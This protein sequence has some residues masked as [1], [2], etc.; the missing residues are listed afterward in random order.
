MGRRIIS[1]EI[2]RTIQV[3]ELERQ[4]K[5]GPKIHNAFSFPTPVRMEE[6]GYIHDPET[7]GEA[8]K[9]KLL[10]EGMHGK[11]LI[12]VLSSSKIAN[13]EVTIPLVKK[14]KIRSVIQYNASEYFPV[15]LAN[16]HVTYK[17][18]EQV[19]TEEGKGLRMLVLAVPMDL[20]RS[21]ADLGR[22]MGMHVLELDYAGNACFQVLKLAAPTGVAVNVHVD[23]ETSTI[24]IVQ[25]GVQ[26]LQRTVGYGMGVAVETILGLDEYKYKGDFR[27]D[28]A[29]EMLKNTPLINPTFDGRRAT[30]GQEDPGF[31]L[32][33]REV[34]ES[35]HFLVNNITRILDFFH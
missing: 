13:R 29:M 23:D 31:T 34:T 16:Y 1:M 21:Y 24:T 2:G 19:Q 28:Q 10:E 15:D 12:F 20:I 32:M 4:G 35:L 3:L 7:L 26:A 8:L 11:E 5:K 30:T 6:D 9:V 22:A 33:K 25:D 17:V 27:A 14:E 18:L